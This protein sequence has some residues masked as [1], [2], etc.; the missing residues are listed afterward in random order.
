MHTTTLQFDELLWLKLQSYLGA[1]DAKMCKFVCRA[2]SEAIDAELAANPG[3][4]SRYEA[5]RAQLLAGAGDN[6]A[7]IGQKRKPRKKAA[8]SQTETA[9][10]E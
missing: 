1:T 5:H 9:A 10:A 3:V 4:K 2:V 6:I 8:Q 7:M